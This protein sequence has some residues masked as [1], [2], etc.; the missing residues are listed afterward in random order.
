MAVSHIDHMILASHHLP[1]LKSTT[2]SGNIVRI[3][4][5]CSNA[6][7]MSPKDMKLALPDELN[8]DLGLNQQYDRSKLAWILYARYL[9]RLLHTSHPKILANATRPDFVET[10]IS[11]DDIREPFP[12]MSVFMAPLKKDKWQR[13]T[14]TLF[15]ATT[16]EKSRGVSLSP[17]DA[18]AGERA[19]TERR[20]GGSS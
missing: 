8:Q 6:H 13:A 9:T 17:C 15:C 14:G 3:S 4:M 11:V 12:G 2:S 20:A 16:I 10:K 5:Q 18:G 7:E 1:L 19:S